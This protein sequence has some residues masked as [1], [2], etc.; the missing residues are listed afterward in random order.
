M[1][2]F[3]LYYEKRSRMKYSTNIKNS[4]YDTAGY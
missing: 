4:F 2:I 1:R 3:A